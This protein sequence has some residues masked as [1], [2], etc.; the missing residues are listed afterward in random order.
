MSVALAVVDEVA[1][2]VGAAAAFATP[3]TP[4]RVT[5]GPAIAVLASAM[6]RPLMPWQRLVA[7]VAT[8]RLDDGSWAYPIVVVTV[9]RQSGKTT[10]MT[11]TW[12]ERCMTSPD[13][14]TWHTAQTRADA[15]DSFLEAAKLL[16]RS[17]LRPPRVTVRRS[18]GSEGFTFPNGASW[19][20]FAPTEDALHG[21]A[22]ALVG[23]D[24]AWA[25][26]GPRGIELEQAI[27]PT[28]TTTGGQ[29][30]IISTAGTA[31]SVWLRGYVERGRAAVAA[32]RREGL[33]YFEWAL[34][35]AEVGPVTAGLENRATD[36]A[37]YLAAL[38]RVLAAHPAYGFDGST[39]RLSALRQ[40]ADVM[41]SGEFL[42]AYANVWTTSSERVI[43]ATA[44][45]ACRVAGPLDR[46]TGPVALGFDVSLD[47][48]HASIVAAWDRPDGRRVVD[49]IEERLGPS[50]SWLPARLVE[51][52]AEHRPV[53]VTYP[54]HGPADDVADQAARLGVT[55]APERGLTAGTYATACAAALGSILAGTWA[56]LG[57]AALDD[58]AAA[59]GTRTLADA[60]AFSRRA[61]A[62]SIAPLGA[63]TSASWALD[64]PGEA[65]K[66]APVIV[67][68]R[69]PAP[70]TNPRRRR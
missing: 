8:E 47:R 55:L 27:L 29:L 5:H 25:H 36:E 69:R 19:R 54:A 3:R 10:L 15:R 60:W 48:G 26:K 28:F 44:W 42:R 33:A 32:G 11:P 63:A 52:A 16:A 20:V 21:K 41:G 23:V 9:P 34:P 46:P 51:L 61:S 45:D 31:E 2:P 49:V 18:N 50:S 66:P 1:A 57:G 24:E 14:L 38:E 30:W 70:L 17:P 58:A 6:N 40:A 12:C 67:A 62:A 35:P 53:A 39:L 22:N 56:H 68:R 7:D 37:G 65:P 64:H 4:G 13:A 59:A 43:P